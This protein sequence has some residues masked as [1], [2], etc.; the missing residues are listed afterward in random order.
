MAS[1]NKIILIGN[2]TRDPAMSY[3]PNQTPVVEF[4]LAVNRRWRDRDGQQREDTCFIDCNA[5]GKQAETINQYMSK[6]RQILVEGQLQYDQWETAEGQKRSKHRVRVMSFQFLDSGQG[7][8]GAGAGAQ[9]PRQAAAPAASAPGRPAPA[10][11]ANA[12]QQEPY[13]NEDFG[14]EAGGEDIPF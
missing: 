10:P 4:G 1:Y 7:R 13:P 5:F 8:Q 9:P 11:A 2:L 14:N 12:P 6:G 3:L